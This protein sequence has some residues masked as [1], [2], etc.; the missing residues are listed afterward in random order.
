MKQAVK[1]DTRQSQLL[2]K[3]IQSKGLHSGEYAL[4][5]VTG[6]GKFLPIDGPVRDR[7]EEASGFVVDNRGRIYSFWLGWGP[8]TACP[9]LTGWEEVPPEP[10]WVKSPEYREAREQVGL[11]P[12]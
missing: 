11:P 5:F 3:L 9:E 4:F 2:H 8:E 12:V 7:I 10:H 1:W 6:E